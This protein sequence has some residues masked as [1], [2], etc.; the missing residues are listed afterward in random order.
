MTIFEK[1]GLDHI[2]RRPSASIVVA[3]GVAVEDATPRGEG[4]R[5]ST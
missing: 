2:R 4:N 1:T 5:S 3:A